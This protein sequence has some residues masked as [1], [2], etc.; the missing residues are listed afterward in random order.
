[1][2]CRPW[3]GTVITAPGWPPGN[4]THPVRW[5]ASLRRKNFLDTQASFESWDR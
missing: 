4:E 2:R 5:V 1:M 3:T